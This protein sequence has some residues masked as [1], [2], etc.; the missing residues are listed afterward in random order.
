MNRSSF[1]ITSAIVPF[2]LLLLGACTSDS[3]TAPQ[4]APLLSRT[5]ESVDRP[6]R[7]A[8]CP[9]NQ[10]YR[11][12]GIFG[13]AGGSLRVAGHRLTIPAGVL[14]EATQFTLHAPAGPHVRLVLSAGGAEHY[15]FQAPV[16]VTISYNRCGR[17]HL[18]RS[19]LSAWN[20]D[21]T[22]RRLVER[23]RG[24]DDRRRRAVTFRTTHFSTYAVCY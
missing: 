20:I 21:D 6:T 23:M 15:T 24:K 18:P 14:T 10:S 3:P 4:L 7:I 8:V 9:T 13:P 11:T 17:Q 16:V 1:R 22:G 19:P 12:E 5:G 2:A